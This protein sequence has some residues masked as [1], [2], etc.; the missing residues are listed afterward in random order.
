MTLSRMLA[1]ILV[2]GA[3]VPVD[4]GRWATLEGPAR[5]MEATW[6]LLR[7]GYDAPLGW[8][9]GGMD[10]WRGAGREVRVMPAPC[11]GRCGPSSLGRSGPS[12]GR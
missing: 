8:L 5:V 9:S 6:H 4:G 7:I 10:A 12:I 2:A 3:V 1:T 11:V